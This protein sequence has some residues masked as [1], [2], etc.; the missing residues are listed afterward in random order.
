MS[1]FYI[2]IFLGLGLLLLVIAIVFF[3]ISIYNKLVTFRNRYEN[4]FAQINVQLTRRYDLIPNLVETAK[5][6]MKHEQET[7][8]AVIEARNKAFAAGQAASKD[9]GDPTAIKNLSSAEQSLGGAL[10]RLL[11]VAEAY[12]DLKAN[13]NMMALQEELTST[14]NKVA[15]ARQG[16]NDAVMTFN[17]AREQFPANLFANTFGFTQAELLELEE[18]KAKIAPKVS[19]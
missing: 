15:Y 1:V 5:G 9:P 11:M 16:F 4:A 3:A 2:V 8:Q 12:P 7:L 19:F 18:P 10:G 13:E 17:T 6:Y 14:E